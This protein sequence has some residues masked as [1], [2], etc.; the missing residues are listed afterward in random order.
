MFSQ[1]LGEFVDDIAIFYLNTSIGEYATTK[2]QCLLA[3]R[4]IFI[5]LPL[6]DN[7]GSVSTAE[8]AIFIGES[9]RIKLAVNVEACAD[10]ASIV[11]RHVK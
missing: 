1:L 8:I 3:Y 6:P 5:L 4:N 9:E 11:L 10:G 7:T 2:K